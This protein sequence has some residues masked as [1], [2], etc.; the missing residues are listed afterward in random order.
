MRDVDLDVLAGARVAQL[1]A[2]LA[3]G[4]GLEDPRVGVEVTR[5]P[6]HLAER[7]HRALGMRAIASLVGVVVVLPA[8]QLVEELDRRAA[9][10]RVEVDV[11]ELERLRLRAAPRLPGGRRLAHPDAV[12]A[13]LDERL[14]RRWKRP[15]SL[16]LTLA[17]VRR[18]LQHRLAPVAEPDLD[19]LMGHERSHRPDRLDPVADLGLA[20]LQ[21][22][23]LD[24]DPRGS[25]SRVGLA[26][27]GIATPPPPGLRR[28]RFHHRR[29]PGRVVRRQRRA[30]ASERPGRTRGR[31]TGAWR[32]S[33]ALPRRPGRASSR[34]ELCH[35]SAT[36]SR[37]HGS[38][39]AQVLTRTVNASALLTMC[40]AIVV[41]IEP[42]RS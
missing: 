30:P 17:H 22:L 5:H 38:V 36:G 27:A 9:V 31:G 33:P 41:S 40:T 29:H 19:P 6:V 8:Q 23:E 20:A 18:P 25:R 12:L 35:G 37:V 32:S 39:H 34:R 26:A 4:Q 3:L 16:P 1:E 7:H 15:K 10:A 24:L 2:A 14:E 11:L 28:R 13:R 21:A 42:V